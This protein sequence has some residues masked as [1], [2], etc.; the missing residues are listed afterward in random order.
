M[1]YHSIIEINSLANGGTSNGYFQ[2]V[3]SAMD[4]LPIAWR[5]HK[6]GSNTQGGNVVGILKLG[7]FYTVRVPFKIDE[8][9]INLFGGDFPR[10]PAGTRIEAGNTILCEI[11]NNAG[12]TFNFTS[13]L[14]GIL[15]P[16][17]MTAP[18]LLVA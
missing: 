10:I 5:I 1:S 17:G 14:S 15:V 3:P 9:A 7:A 8:F 6:S 18:R 12:A 4:L 13:E 16:R 11:T 2:Q